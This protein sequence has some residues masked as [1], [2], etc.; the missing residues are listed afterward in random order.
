MPKNRVQLFFEGIQITYEDAP[1]L[2]IPISI[3]FLGTIGA[4]GAW[5]TVA[6]LWSIFAVTTLLI[7]ATQ[8]HLYRST[9]K[10]LENQQNKIQA[11][12]S[13]Y[14]FIDFKHSLPPMTGWAATPELALT[15]YEQIIDARPDH[16]VEIGSG[17]STLIA[18]YG[19]KQNN[20]GTVY[21]LDHDP[22]FAQKTREQLEKHGLGDFG[23]I[24]NT[25]LVQH[26]MDG[27][28][29]HWYNLENVDLPEQIDLLLVDGPPVKT[30]N[31]ARYP[32]LPLLYEK[33]SDH[34][35]IILH[36]AHRKSESSIIEEWLSKYPEFENSLLDTEKG[37][38]I[39]KR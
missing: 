38:A 12:F 18:G 20:K 33:L 28:A 1:Y 5:G 35:V 21:S 27:E 17:I 29:W 14:S 32:A 10:D 36:D 39:L 2:Y 3:A 37:I 31:K 7:L 15:L 4:W 8:F 26:Q 13:L 16:M 25:P 34:A 11:Y 22:D 30:S 6:L 24:I 19:F 23:R 9:Q